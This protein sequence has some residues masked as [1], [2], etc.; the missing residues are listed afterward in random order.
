LSGAESVGVLGGTFDPVHVA[1]LHAA[2][3]VRAVFGLRRVLLVPCARS[4][5]KPD[6]EP[7]SAED[8]LAMLRL[9]AGGSEGIE[10]ATVELD[11]GGI[12][13]TVDTLRELA[14][15]ATPLV[16]VFILG[17][18]ALLEFTGWKEW[19]ALVREF[20]LVAADR[21]G[22]ALKDLRSRLPEGIATRIIPV[23]FDPGAGTRLGGPPVGA[24][25]RIYFL[26]LP[27]VDVSSSLVRR[28]AARGLPLDGLVPPEVG[29]YIQQRGLYAE[30]GSH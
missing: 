1:H 11:R 28:R 29:R 21:P 9:A 6:R 13:Y 24:G 7:S 20:D 16:P 12:S 2:T 27:P 8:R 5:Y 14:S 26:S 10:V 23:P 15:G 19:T 4:P 25:G 3:S 22:F 17:S 30:E 18:D